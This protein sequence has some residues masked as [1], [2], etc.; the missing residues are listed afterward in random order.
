M[1]VVRVIVLKWLFG[2]CRTLA[3]NALSEVCHTWKVIWIV[4][5]NEVSFCTNTD[6]IVS[7]EEKIKWCAAKDVLLP[8]F[9]I[10]SVEIFV[11][12]VDEYHVWSQPNQNHSSFVLKSNMM[13]RH[14]CQ[15]DHGLVPLEY[16]LQ[17]HVNRSSFSGRWLS[18]ATI[19]EEHWLW[20]F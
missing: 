15:V 13:R 12:A 10:I 9:P 16:L 14:L 17:I 11:Q 20:A 19:S 18:N 6:H 4:N 8:F 3:F 5:N 2:I 7:T 1:L